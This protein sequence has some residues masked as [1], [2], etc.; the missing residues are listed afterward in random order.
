MEREGQQWRAMEDCSTDE[1]LQQE[2]LCHRQWTDQYV[3]RPETL[4]RQNVVVVW[5]QCLLVDKDN[6][7]SLKLKNNTI[8]LANLHLRTAE[9]ILQCFR[10][11][12]DSNQNLKTWDVQDRQVG[13]IH[14]TA[15]IIT[16]IGGIHNQ[17]K[18]NLSKTLRVH[19]QIPICSDAPVKNLT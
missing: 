13:S 7:D 8:C 3:S 1:R 5:I 17:I 15:L 2:T 19:N 10:P 12:S 16:D 9:T 6:T 14:R 4:M 11:Q 18:I